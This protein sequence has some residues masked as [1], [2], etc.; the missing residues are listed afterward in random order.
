[1]GDAAPLGPHRADEAA[2]RLHDLRLAEPIGGRSLEAVD[3][4][5]PRLLVHVP[6][7]ALIGL[8]SSE[9]DVRRARGADMH[10]HVADIR[11]EVFGNLEAQGDIDPYEVTQRHPLE[12]QPAHVDPLRTS[13][14]LAPAAALVGDDN[15][16]PPLQF[17]GKRARACSDVG[18][19]TRLRKGKRPVPAP[20]PHRAKEADDERTYRPIDRGAH[21]HPSQPGYL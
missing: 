11:P 17:G 14:Q 16:V 20:A 4:V 5:T 13:D 21:S 7:A 10:K 19:A 6:A 18:I 3:P 15:L 9:D 8:G 1:M 12:L 2:I